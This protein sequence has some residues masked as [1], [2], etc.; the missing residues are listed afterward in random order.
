[1]RSDTIDNAAYADVEDVSVDITVDATAKI[2]VLQAESIPEE[3]HLVS[4]NCVSN[5][6]NYST[7]GSVIIYIQNYGFYL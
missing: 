6:S 4:L 7:V 5:G 1:V 2:A 3:P